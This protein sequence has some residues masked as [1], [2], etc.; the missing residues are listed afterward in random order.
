[1]I[2]ILIENSIASWR[3]ETKADNK[4]ELEREAAKVI[5]GKSHALLIRNDTGTYILPEKILKESV[6]TII[7]SEDYP[8]T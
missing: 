3:L 1:M 5:S 2:E 8:K 4:N 7:E 6:I